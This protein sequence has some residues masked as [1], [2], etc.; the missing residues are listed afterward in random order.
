MLS[1]PKL[2]CV[3]QPGEKQERQFLGVK[4]H[5]PLQPPGQA[6]GKRLD[7]FLQGLAIGGSGLLLLTSAT[8]ALSGWGMWK[9][10]KR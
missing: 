9:V 7:F 6:P 8:L 3:A 2:F 5:E 4:S 10:I 1:V